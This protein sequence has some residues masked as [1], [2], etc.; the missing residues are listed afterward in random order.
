MILLITY[1]LNLFD[2]AMTSLWVKHYGISVEANPIGRWLL[3]TNLA[4]VFKIFAVGGLLAV[5]GYLLK[6]YPKHAWTAYIPLTAYTVLAVY[7][8]AIFFCT[9]E[10][11]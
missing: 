4:W 6:R 2:L 5:L 9:K 10:I 1:L 3:D 8:I 7:H 11:L